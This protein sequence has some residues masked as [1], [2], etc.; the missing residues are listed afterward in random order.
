MA[1][2]LRIEFADATYHITSR[3]DRRE[4]IFVE[5][6]D[7]REL[8]S[9]IEEALQ[10]FEAV[11]LAYCLMGNHYHFILNTR[12]ANLSL[13]MRHVNGVYTQRFN[14]RHHKT[15]HLFQGRFKAIL[16]DCDRYLAELCRYV[17]L[18]P[19][20]ANLVEGPQHWPWS[21]YRAHVGLERAPLWLDV[22]RL[23][24]WLLGRPVRGIDDRLLAAQRYAE[25]VAQSRDA[26]LWEHALRQQIYLGDETFVARMQARAESARLS[27]REVHK[28]QRQMPK[29]AA[30]WIADSTSRNEGIHLANRVGGLTVSSI[31]KELGLSVS[32]ICRIVLKVEK[33]GARKKT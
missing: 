26:G 22:E 8:L 28:S 14:R 27:S 29:N 10:R 2:P 11:L 20:R 19:V 9:T 31:A 3:G 18:N 13:L 1:R 12:R 17:E 30:A 16:V 24:E 21:S 32:R 25:L 23:H 6:A 4:A 15:G 5:D 33:A 7:R